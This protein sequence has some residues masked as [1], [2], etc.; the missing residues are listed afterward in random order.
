MNARSTKELSSEGVAPII[1]ELMPRR[2]VWT[3]GSRAIAI[4]TGLLAGIYVSYMWGKTC[5]LQDY[6]GLPKRTEKGNWDA[7]RCD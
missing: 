7:L 6:D 5:A 2:L 3:A 1:A 4:A